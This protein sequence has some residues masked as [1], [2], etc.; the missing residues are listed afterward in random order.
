MI[1]V[2]GLGNVPLILQM[3]QRG[4]YMLCIFRAESRV[5]S[6]KPRVLSLVW[7][8]SDDNGPIGGIYISLSVHVDYL[9]LLVNNDKDT[10][11]F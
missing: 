2:V 5:G 9:I 3:H 6:G 10:F 8:H 4:F 1:S 7:E 11:A